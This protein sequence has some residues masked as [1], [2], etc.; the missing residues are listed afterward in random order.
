MHFHRGLDE[1]QEPGERFSVIL[2]VAQNQSRI[3]DIWHIDE[4]DICELCDVIV[5]RQIILLKGWF[6]GNRIVERL[7]K[8]STEDVYL[9]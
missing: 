1:N 9:L 6:V 3:F 2:L 5:M 8:K 4:R 7:A